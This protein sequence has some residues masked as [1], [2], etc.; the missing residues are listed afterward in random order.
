MSCGRIE[1]FLAPV[2]ALWLL[3]GALAP[4]PPPAAAPAPAMTFDTLDTTVCVPVLGLRRASVVCGADVNPA[5]VSVEYFAPDGSATTVDTLHMAAD[6]SAQHVIDV[7]HPAFAAGHG[8]LRLSAANPNPSVF[9]AWLWRGGAAFPVSGDA[10]EGQA[11]RVPYLATNSG[12][13]RV[14]LAV[15]NPNVFAVFVSIEN[16]ATGATVNH[17]L[18]PL[19][20]VLWD[21]AAEGQPVITDSAVRVISTGGGV[22]LAASTFRNGST[23]LSHPAVYLD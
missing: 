12:D 20:T 13:Q 7:H 9:H 19:Q 21:S 14:V 1:S 2:L 8:M 5:D 16:L 23:I 17:P 18:D 10:F 3:V 22:V 15:S 6:G 11:F 4:A